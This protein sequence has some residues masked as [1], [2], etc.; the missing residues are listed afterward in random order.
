MTV[1]K[2]IYITVSWALV[3]A[4]M[5]VIFWMSSRTASASSEMSDSLIDRILALLGI[6]FSSFIIRKTAHL[7]E[8]TGLAMLTFNAY[9]STFRRAAAPVSFIITV[10]YA[11]S[12]EVH[13]IFVDGRACQLRDVLIDSGG[14]LLGIIASLI[15]LK[16]IKCA[17]ERRNKNITN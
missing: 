2:K 13:Q 1:K 15:I 16:I 5:G 7:L 8:F 14:A 10:L 17:V 4:C 11:V 3:I 6:E 9:Y 12:D